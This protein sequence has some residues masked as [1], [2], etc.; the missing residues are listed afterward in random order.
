M[1][2]SLYNTHCYLNHLVLA[3]NCQ[4]NLNRWN[5]IQMKWEISVQILRRS[6]FSENVKNFL[7]AQNPESVW[8]FN[9][10]SW[11]FHSS[12]ELVKTLRK[13]S[14]KINLNLSIAYYYFYDSWV[15]VDCFSWGG[16]SLARW[17][18][19]TCWCENFV[20]DMLIFLYYLWV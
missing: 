20:P 11:F 8:R 10:K 16:S 19:K 15:C 1:L 6:I 9:R 12:N 2:I 3:E 5:I 13:N 14:C 7:F 18:F 4:M 17:Q